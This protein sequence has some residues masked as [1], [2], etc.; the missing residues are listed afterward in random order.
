MSYYKGITLFI[1]IWKIYN[2]IGEIFFNDKT[3]K[4]RK[5]IRLLR[6]LKLNN[7]KIFLDI[8]YVSWQ[9]IEFEKINIYTE[10]R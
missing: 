8:G 6:W 3:I 2:L 7:H 10:K 4:T 1:I 5:I 9:K